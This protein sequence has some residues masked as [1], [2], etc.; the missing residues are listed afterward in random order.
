MKKNSKNG[1]T[2]VTLVILIVLVGI[3]YLMI[4]NDFWDSVGSKNF[5]S[6]SH[7]AASNTKENGPTPSILQFKDPFKYDK[8]EPTKKEEFLKK[9]QEN[10][11]NAEGKPLY[12]K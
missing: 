12:W 7:V 1:N 11:K 8:Y 6:P 9:R 5:K 3:I 2:V 10:G 4:P